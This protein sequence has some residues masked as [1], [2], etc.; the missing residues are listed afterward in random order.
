MWVQKVEG[1][2]TYHKCK[3]CGKV[4]EEELKEDIKES[5]E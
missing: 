3:R 4:V 5:E 1:N 2:K